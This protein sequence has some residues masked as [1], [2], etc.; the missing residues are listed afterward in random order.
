MEV[1]IESGSEVRWS[2]SEVQV[3]AAMASDLG[4]LLLTENYF[5]GR[6]EGMVSLN[7]SS[8]AFV[9]AAST[10]SFLI[11]NFSRL[12]SPVSNVLTCTTLSTL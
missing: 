4:M 1:A 9:P 6:V 10:T 7:H 12:L 3:Y 2:V 11:L 5:F 8:E